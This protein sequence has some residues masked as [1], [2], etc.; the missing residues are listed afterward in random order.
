MTVADDAYWFDIESAVAADFI[1]RMKMYRLRAKAEIDPV[2]SHAVVW[3]PDG[4]APPQG[5]AASYRDER[6]PSLGVRHMVE[7]V[8]VGAGW[9][10]AQAVGAYAPARIAAGVLELGPDFGSN[11]MFPHDIGMD[12]LHAVD[13]KKG[14][15]VG[16]E[17]VSRMQHRGTARRRPAIVSGLPEGAATKAQVRVGERDIGEIGEAAGG[18]AVAAVRLD[19]VT[20]GAV[21]TFAGV[22][23][24]LDLPAWATYRFGEAAAE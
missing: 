14:C 6:G 23:V 4:A 21:A 1:R 13:F 22:P 2:E 24:M 18:R 12:L 16:Q 9:A 20:E 17:V 3:S 8:A 15:Y 7:R 11:E 10:D 19:R 5:V